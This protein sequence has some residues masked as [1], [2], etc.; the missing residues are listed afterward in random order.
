MDMNKEH[1]TR[2]TSEVAAHL[3]AAAAALR[4]QDIE[5]I[6]KALTTA[7]A[8]YGKHPSCVFDPSSL[9]RDL[10][11]AIRAARS[12][13]RTLGRNDDDLGIIE[14]LADS[15]RNSPFH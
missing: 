15:L 6:V 4:H 14:E 13:C 8:L 10:L 3:D 1:R 5:G 2:I 11:V 12:L 9:L 7:V